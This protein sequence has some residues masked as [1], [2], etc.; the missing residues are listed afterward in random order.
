MCPKRDVHRLRRIVPVATIVG[1]IPFEAMSA[2]PENSRESNGV[3][4]RPDHGACHRA[5]RAPSGFHDLGD[6]APQVRM[7][8]APLATP[9]RAADAG[10]PRELDMGILRR[11]HVDMLLEPGLDRSLPRCP[12]DARDDDV[13]VP[14]L[15]LPGVQDR[16]TRLAC[17]W[18][19]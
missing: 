17:W 12:V 8:R 10:R 11:E 2:T 13:D 1:R 4:R 7:A 9:R 19:S 5:Q 14:A 6:P 18:V 16:Q 3:V 15:Q